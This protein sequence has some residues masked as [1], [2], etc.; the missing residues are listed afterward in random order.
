M[1]NKPKTAN[2][3]EITKTFRDLGLDDPELRRRLKEFSEPS[4]WAARVNRRYYA[5]S[6]RNNTAQDVEERNA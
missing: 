5:L 1:N 6:T 3:E 2:V 4:K